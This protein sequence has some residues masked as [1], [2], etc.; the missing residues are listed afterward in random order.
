VFWLS[1]Q[2]LSEKFLISIINSLAQELFFLFY[3]ILY[4]KCE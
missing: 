1:L 4:I 3:H 2:L